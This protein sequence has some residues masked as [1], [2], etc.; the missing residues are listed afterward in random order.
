MPNYLYLEQGKWSSVI[1]FVCMP[2]ELE[3]Q[4]AIYTGV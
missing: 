3:I 1:S 2:E 4:S